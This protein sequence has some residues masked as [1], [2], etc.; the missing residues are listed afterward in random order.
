ML[1]DMHAGRAS[2]CFRRQL[3]RDLP[4][5]K[6]VVDF[7]WSIVRVGPVWV[8]IAEILLR[9]VFQ[10]EGQRARWLLPI[11]MGR[12]GEI[13]G[14]AASPGAEEQDGNENVRNDAIPLS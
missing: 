4:I 6:A 14:F 5:I 8:V 12:I 2:Q 3:P 9:D 7:A 10:L 11:G 13:A 1:V